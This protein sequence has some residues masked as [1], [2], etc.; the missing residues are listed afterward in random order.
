[1]V[2][3][4]SDMVSVLETLFGTCNLYEILGCDRNATGNQIKKAYHRKA[5]QL[6]P[7][8]HHGKSEDKKLITQ[9]FQMISVV[10][11]VLND[12]EK[13]SV[14]DETG[15]ILDGSEGALFSGGRDWEQYWREIYKQISEEDIEE[16]KSK[17]VGSE[18]ELESVKA[19]YV[20][21]EGDM[22]QILENVMCC[23]SED[24]PR[25]RDMIEEE[26]RKGTVEE[27]KGFREESESKKKSR[28]RKAKKEAA[29]AAELA[30]ELGLGSKKK[31]SEADL[32]ALI[33]QRQQSR[34]AFFSDLEAKYSSS[35]GAKGKKKSKKHTEPSEEE[36][37][38]IQEKM[39]SKTR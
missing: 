2:E 38:R 13:R 19:A 17:F 26:I 31:S 1:M 33:G 25:F 28:K 9:K 4:N 39:L 22:S 23:T 32:F 16:F 11:S 8:R 6:H 15:Q 29:E 24:E 37:Q 3:D 20:E 34:K 14:Y 21:F 10:Y 12:S 5:L 7:D 27:Y 35:K 30:K 36:F 18:E